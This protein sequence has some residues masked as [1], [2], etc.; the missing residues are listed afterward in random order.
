[1]Q[2]SRPRHVAFD[3]DIAP[4]ILARIAA[5]EGITRICKDP[6]F[7]PVVA[8]YEWM[9]DNEDFAKSYARARDEQADTLADEITA[10]ADD[11][12]IPADSRRIRVDARKWVASKLKP[13][14][15]GDKLTQEHTGADGGPMQFAE[16][17]RTIVD[18]AKEG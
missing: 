9:R 5:G 7:P 14:R 10:I 12:T 17:R 1:M 15:Y 11:E 2:K 6:G 4:T 8:V 16:V 13:K 18:P 3:P